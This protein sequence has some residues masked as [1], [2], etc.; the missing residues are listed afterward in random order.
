[1]GDIEFGKCEVCGKE[2]SLQ[3]SCFYYDIECECHSP[4]HFEFVKHCR[5]CIPKEPEI[6]KI[7]IKTANLIKRDQ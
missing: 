2:T 7:T 5:N 1:M 4:Y 3:R 6:T